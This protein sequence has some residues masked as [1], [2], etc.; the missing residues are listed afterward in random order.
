MTDPLKSAAIQ[1]AV[2]AGEEN[3]FATWPDIPV[4]TAANS[5]A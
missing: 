2:D 3:R 1:D 4:I 5:I